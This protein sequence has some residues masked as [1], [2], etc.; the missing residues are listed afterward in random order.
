MKKLLLWLL[1]LTLLAALACGC[2]SPAKERITP[3]DFTWDPHAYNAYLTEHLGEELTEKYHAWVDAILAGEENL[4]C[5]D[6]DELDALTG[7]LRT[8]FPPFTE[9]VGDYTLEDGELR[10]SYN[11]TPEERQTLVEE[12][13]RTVEEWI[14]TSVVEG[15]TPLMAALSLYHDYSAYV[16]YIDEGMEDDYEGDLSAW[17]G[18]MEGE[19]ICQT[20][21]AAYAY[22]AMQAGL[23]CIVAG[24]LD[25]DNTQA[26]DWT[27]FRLGDKDFFADPTF[28]NGWGGEGLYFFGMTGQQRAVDGY[29][30]ANVN[31]G[32]NLAEGSDLDVTDERFAPFWTVAQ[33]LEIRRP[34]E[35]MELRCRDDL[36][37]EFTV[38]ITPED[39]VIVK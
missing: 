24:G 9:L 36:G 33:V 28:E 23:D 30:L 1:S 37:E 3:V 34:G 14:E 16:T 13:G 12:F 17:N 19:G 35:N 7:A 32:W 26:H 11:F 39:Q 6:W 18:I 4:P 25:A 2:A 10:L 31:V 29:P 22:L 8:T 27:V 5:R 20:F 21:A 15:D 38:V